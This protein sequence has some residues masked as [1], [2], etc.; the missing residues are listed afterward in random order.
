MVFP[1]L[2]GSA[3]R[4]PDRPD[5]VT[6]MA[7]RR[8]PMLLA[9]ILVAGALRV[10]GLFDDLWLDEIWSI[11]IAR[12]LHHWSDVLLSPVAQCDNN[13]P[14]NTAFLWMMGAQTHWWVYRLLSLLV[15]IASVVVVAVI[16]ARRDHGAARLATALVACS[17]PLVFYSSEAR[18]YALV[19]FFALLAFDALDRYLDRPRAVTAL[20]FG[21]ACLLG[22]LSHLTFIHAYAGMLAWSLYR[23]GPSLN[24]VRVH[25]LPIA[26]TIGIY[27]VFV[28]KL[29]IG[30]APPVALGPALAIGISSLVAGAGAQGWE[31]AVAAL[32]LAEFTGVLVSLGR[33]GN[34]LWV[35]LLV[36]RSSHPRSCWRW[37]Q[38]VMWDRHRS[39]LAMS[40]CC[41]R[42]A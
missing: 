31:T 16:M 36:G 8:D 20:V 1:T 6:A 35:L 34:D 26:T 29:V 42:S 2:S 28:R 14:L 17:H 39:T 30:G 25:F 37:R 7:L 32:A 24:L 4:S 40:S 33:R 38:F 10:P 5:V 3:R 18:G 15:G 12:E 23:R 21:G 19:V 9:L 27:L 11:R 22:F 41:C 13:A